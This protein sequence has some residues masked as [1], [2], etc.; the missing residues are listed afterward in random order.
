MTRTLQ[1]RENGDDARGRYVNGKLVFPDGELLY[2]LGQAAHQPSSIS[3]HVIGF[4]L[5][6][7]GWINERGFENAD[8]ISRGHSQVLGLL[9]H[10]D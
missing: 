8:M 7:V 6:L 4:A 5:V 3:V 10:V 9:G 2:V 1:K